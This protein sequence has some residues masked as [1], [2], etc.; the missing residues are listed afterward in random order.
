[1][2]PRQD[3]RLSL[4]LRAIWAATAILLLSP[5]RACAVDPAFHISQYGHTAWRLH[6]GIFTGTP[7]SIAQTK[8][9]FIWIG[10]TDGLFRFDGVRFVRW[11]DIAPDRQ[12]GSAEIFAI[13][14]ARD[15]SL[16]IGAA[17]GLFRW[18]KNRLTRYPLRSGIVIAMN[19]TNEG[20][21]WLARARILDTDGALCQVKDD[22]IHCHGEADGVPLPYA[23]AMTADA[24]G[25]IWI[26][27]DTQLVRWRPDSSSL[28]HIKHSIRMKGLDGIQALAVDHNHSV[29]VG[30]DTK[31]G[32]GLQ[33]FRK[34]LWK[35]FALP[36]LGKT[37]GA[38]S[39]LFVDHAN[40]LWVGTQG[41]GIYRII[42]GQIDHFD[43]S[44]GLS[45]N[46][47]QAL[48]E[49]N[50]GDI[51]VDT[52]TGIDCFH[53]LPI[54]TFSSRE[55]LHSDSAQSVLPAHD[56]TVWIGNVGA[57]DAL[58]NGTVTSILP[59]G[60]LPGRIITSLAESSQGK[61]WVGI[62]SGLFLF[63]HGKFSSVI[64]RDGNSYI[65]AM[66]STQDGTVWTLRGSNGTRTDDL[67][68]IVDGHWRLRER[69][70]LD[71]VRLD[72]LGIDA[73]GRL[74]LAGSQLRYWS[75][76]EERT[77]T[78]FGPEYGN[79][80]GIAV[81]SAGT[82]WF[83]ATKGLLSFREGKL[84]AITTSNGLPCAQI[85][86]L[87]IDRHRALWLYTQCG[88][89]RIGH[90]ELERWWNQPKIQLRVSVFDTLDGFEGGRTAVR[91]AAAESADG[92]L[93]FVNGSVV[94][95][96]NPD[97][98]YVNRVP[99]PVHIDRIIDKSRDYPAKNGIRL[100]KLTVDL[101]IRYT[102]LSFVVP[103][104]V[105]FR[106][107]LDGYDTKWS[108]VGAR[109]SA[110]YTNL[111][112]GTYRFMV[113][114]CNNSGVWNLDGA[115][116][117][118]VI[119]PAWYQTLWF[120]LLIVAL[121]VLL[122]CGVYL[123]RMRQYSLALKMRFDERLDERTRIAR[124]LHDTL[125]QSFH[126]LL[127]R[128]QAARNLMPRKTESAIQVLDEAISATE[129]ALAEG[130][131]AIHDLRPEPE[132]QRDLAEL[133]I[134]AGN[135]IAKAELSNDFL[136]ELRVIVEGKSRRLFPTLQGEVYRIGREEIGRAHV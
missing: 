69:D 136:P 47:I 40:A 105:R 111:R 108:Y 14:A 122:A 72:T 95:T 54:V 78:A 45:G 3:S 32:I 52:S 31:V 50:E 74:W 49:D 63:E 26:G 4:A 133:L 80:R 2:S 117:I 65:M 25:N 29:W 39:S 28:I 94:Q 125:L 98:L 57:L 68:Q 6:D 83:G 18:N 36:L 93:W 123:L 30:M 107:K 33:Q 21:I 55:G 128:V 101:E 76:S 102:G 9:G 135:E 99:P 16:W 60:G 70:P 75:G 34:G 24:G 73:Q 126:G 110:F 15:G 92:R 41:H 42:N 12:L 23:A 43:R 109:R 11:S 48:F 97:E 84:K 85:N 119:P 127:F 124:E 113:G 104:R 10:T 91:P 8:D 19:Q 96:L 27:A 131:D 44:D 115:T 129:R 81:D 64:P 112:P 1:M 88:L 89:I 79:I 58:H 66:A 86:A 46:Q 100:P 130:R 22:G 61:L 116:L 106:Y 62:D 7:T 56:G 118:F 134:L 121:L 59:S 77:I 51:W 87:V 35:R 20:A 71:E 37:D 114:A 90:S 120:R 67:I 13:L 53:N 82:V 38:V 17:D 5:A 132:Q 103:Q